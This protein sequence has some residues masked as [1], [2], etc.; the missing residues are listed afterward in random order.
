MISDNA[1]PETCGNENNTKYTLVLVGVESEES[2]CGGS[3]T[4]SLRSKKGYS[5]VFFRVDKT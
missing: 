5:K 1:P 4:H 3:H 2:E